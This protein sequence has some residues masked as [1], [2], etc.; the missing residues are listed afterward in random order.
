MANPLLI[1]KGKETNEKILKWLYEFKYSKAVILQKITGLT[2]AGIGE[3]LRKLEHR[4]LVQSLKPNPPLKTVWGITWD[5]ICEIG[6][7]DENQKFEPSKF[8][9]ITAIH[10]YNLQELKL[11]LATKNLNLVPVKRS[12]V[13]ATEKTPDGIVKKDDKIIAIELERTVKTKNRYK[14][15][16]G[17][18]IEDIRKG[19]YTNVQYFLPNTRTQNLLK[20]FEQTQ[21]IIINKQSVP[22]TE[23]LKQYFKFSD[24]SEKINK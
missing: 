13:G 10:H 9:E 6:E 3:S 14:A 12:S 5:G 8:N 24:I 11:L 22:F 1:K 4:G 18:Y 23:S 20:I 19:K 2:R 16:W 7:L 17:G 21:T 15:I